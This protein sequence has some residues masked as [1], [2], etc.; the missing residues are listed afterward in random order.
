MTTNA[1]LV[2]ATNNT[3]KRA[4]RSSRQSFVR[5]YRILIRNE[6]SGLLSVFF[7]QGHPPSQRLRFE[8]FSEGLF[9]SEREKIIGFQT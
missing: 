3:M 9:E 2:K 8:T 6:Y 4:H 5:E 7:N 1:E